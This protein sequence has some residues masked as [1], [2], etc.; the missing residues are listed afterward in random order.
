MSDCV[1][2]AG[3]LAQRPRRAGHAWVFVNWLRGLRR[4]GCRALFVDRLSPELG[5]VDAGVRWVHEVMARAGFDG[6]WTVLLP[7]GGA[8]GMT[9]R[10]LLQHAEDAWL[11]NIMG[12]LDDPELLAAVRRRV[13]LDLDPGFT[14]SWQAS[15]SADLL[16]GHDAFA[17]VGLNIG[18]PDCRVPNV[19]VEWIPTLP[20]VDLDLWQ[21]E[22]SAAGPFTTVGSWR[23]PFDPIDVDGVRY[24][25]RAHE[26]R[27]HA[28]LP[29]RTGV[30]LEAALD[31]DP[32]DEGDRARLE[33]GGWELHDPREVSGDLC[34]YRDYVH[35]SSA[36]FAVA[37][38][39][40]VGLRTGW[41]SDRSACY[42]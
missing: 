31:I 19:G 13:F 35:G 3:A 36:E 11:L 12:Y 4:C 17:T 25:L 10:D 24:G 38:Q 29:A 20:P 26:A 40:Y 18:A 8:A 28:D 33:L 16:R 37:K 22:P 1:L 34:A 9:R 32:W 2:V 15:G 27:A 39:A 23:G 5:D 42:L 6:A 41:F 7:D 21:C 14:Q 30:A